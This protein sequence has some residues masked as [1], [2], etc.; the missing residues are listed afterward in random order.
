MN[1][2]P[3]SLNGFSQSLLDF[4]ASFGGND[5]RALTQKIGKRRLDVEDGTVHTDVIV[6]IG[7]GSGGHVDVTIKLSYGKLAMPPIEMVNVNLFSQVSDR[8]IAFRSK[9][10]GFR[11]T[12]IRLR[13]DASA[14]LFWCDISMSRTQYSDGSNIELA[15]ATNND[16]GLAGG[17][18]GQQL[19]S[20][21]MTTQGTIGLHSTL[22]C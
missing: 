1:N 9:I 11:Q 6:F 19:L 13:V 3:A 12:M 21:T 8:E 14:T 16:I 17:P 7:P 4:L 18:G 2:N 15:V 22:P 20:T 5:T 10:G